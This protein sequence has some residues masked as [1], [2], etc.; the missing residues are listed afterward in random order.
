MRSW[1]GLL[2]QV[3]YDFSVAD[4]MQPFRHLLKPNT[5]FQW[6]SE[7]D[8]IFEESKV[9]IVR[10]IEEGVRIFDMSKPTCLATGQRQ[11]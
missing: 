7:L 11:A 8:A 6:T 10:E 5:P 1:F 9:A 3:A 2:N 4:R